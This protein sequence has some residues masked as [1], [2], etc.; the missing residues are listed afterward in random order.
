MVL[1]RWTTAPSLDACLDAQLPQH[2]DDAATCVSPD[3]KRLDTSPALP[4]WDHWSDVHGEDAP[5]P[6]P[7]HPLDPVTER[8][9][10]S[11]RL[12]Y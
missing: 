9:A 2:H 1:S 11:L 12:G 6:V 5:A 8:L 10:I 4:Q 7:A 3:G